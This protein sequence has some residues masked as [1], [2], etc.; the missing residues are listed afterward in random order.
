[1]ERVDVGLRRL[2]GLQSAAER[3]QLLLDDIIDL[4]GVVS[5]VALDGER[6]VIIGNG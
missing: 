1:M 3:A 2:F 5:Y 6:R 4:F